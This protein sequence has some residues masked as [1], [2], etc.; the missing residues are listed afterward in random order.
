M[1]PG[2]ERLSPGA[3]DLPEAIGRAGAEEGRH[4]DA[5]R[6]REIGAG[7]TRGRAERQGLAGA[8]RDAGPAFE[9]LAVE[10]AGI[11]APQTATT[12]SS[13]KRRVGPMNWHSSPAA[14]AS[15]PTRRLAMRK[16]QPS[17]G[18]EIG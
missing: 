1:L 12:R 10:R 3:A 5:A 16:D 8:D 9:G 4:V 11:S 13:W 17:I 18:P 6:D 14:L 7:A 2:L 15:L